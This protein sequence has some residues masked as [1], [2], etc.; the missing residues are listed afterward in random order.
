MHPVDVVLTL[1]FFELE[2]PPAFPPGKGA[3]AAFLPVLGGCH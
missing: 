3:G 2:E 1:A